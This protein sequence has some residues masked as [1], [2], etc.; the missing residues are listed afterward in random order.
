MPT[1]PR[2]HVKPQ[3]T[4]LGVRSSNLFGRASGFNN[5]T[6]GG[7]QASPM[8]NA[9]RAKPPLGISNQVWVIRLVL[10]RATQPCSR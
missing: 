10:K 3:T 9:G 1:I 8:N 6:V 2:E 4:N 7:G 5:L